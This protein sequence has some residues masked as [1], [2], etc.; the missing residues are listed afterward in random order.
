MIGHIDKDVMNYKFYQKSIRIFSINYENKKSL[1]NYYACSIIAI[2]KHKT[3]EN[4][5]ILIRRIID[6]PLNRSFVPR[7]Q[8]RIPIIIFCFRSKSFS[9][10][11]WRWFPVRNSFWRGLWCASCTYHPKGGRISVEPSSG[12]A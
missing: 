9:L 5:P 2:L 3:R 4:S 12:R 8:T 7:D 10:D 1:F 11:P 6:T